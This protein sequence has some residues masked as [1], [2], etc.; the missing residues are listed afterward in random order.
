[1]LTGKLCYKG[2][3]QKKVAEQLFKINNKINLFGKNAEKFPSF[4][5]AMKIIP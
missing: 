4:K 2:Q 1:M 3:D 5:M